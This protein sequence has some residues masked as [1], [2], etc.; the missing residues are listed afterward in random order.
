VGGPLFFRRCPDR[1]R[2]GWRYFTCSAT[3]DLWQGVSLDSDRRIWLETSQPESHV[4][5]SANEAEADGLEHGLC[6][7]A[8]SS[9]RVALLTWR[10]AVVSLVPAVLCGFSR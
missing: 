4:L 7:L 10:A 5:R 1:G 8:Q 6:L 9:F 3:F 2:E